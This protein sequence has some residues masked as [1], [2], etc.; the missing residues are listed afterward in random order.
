M[1]KMIRENLDKVGSRKPA[2]CSSGLIVEHAGTVVVF[3]ATLVDGGRSLKI[4]PG[5]KT[6][7]A[8]R[9]IKVS[10]KFPIE[11]FCPSVEGTVIICLLTSGRGRFYD[12]LTGKHLTAGEM[13][14]RV[15]KGEFHFYR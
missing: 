11:M 9:T 2:D 6:G 15:Q 14:S 12:T 4:T 13:K 7:W 8:G 1:K 3:R 5:D 10:G